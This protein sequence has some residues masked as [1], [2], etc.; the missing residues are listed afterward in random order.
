MV[1]VMMMLMAKELVL[2]LAMMKGLAQQCHH[3]GLCILECLVLSG[4]ID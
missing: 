3:L 4:R 1:M 2:D